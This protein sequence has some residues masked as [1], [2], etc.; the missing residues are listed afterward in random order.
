MYSDK[1][2]C[3][4]SLDIDHTAS[5]QGHLASHL[6]NTHYTHIYRYLNG[7]GL[8]GL[9]FNSPV[10]AIKIM[11]NW[12]VYLTTLFLGSLTSLNC[13]PIHM[14]ILVPEIDNL[15]QQSRGERLQKILYDQSPPKNGPGLSGNRTATFR[16]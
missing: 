1:Q 13:L 5:D 14:H 4:N 16:F 9:V 10:N 6:Y 3:I 12:S 11:L 2:A 15:N 8:V 7:L